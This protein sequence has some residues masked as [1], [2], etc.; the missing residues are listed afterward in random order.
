[1]KA[2]FPRHMQTFIWG[3]W[4]AVSKQQ[5]NLSLYLLCE[6]CMSACDYNI[7]IN[8]IYIS[9]RVQRDLECSNTFAKKK[10]NQNF[11]NFGKFLGWFLDSLSTEISFRFSNKQSYSAVPCKIGPKIQFFCNSMHAALKLLK[12]ILN[13]FLVYFWKIADRPAQ[14]RKIAIQ[15]FGQIFD[16]LLS[17][18]LSLISH[19]NTEM[20]PLIKYRCDQY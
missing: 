2:L 16:I 11:A 13:V 4:P 14:C 15:K 8:Y 1:M 3:V 18:I 19:Q 6:R 10:I 20:L 7:Y 17:E 9:V 5:Q 12:G